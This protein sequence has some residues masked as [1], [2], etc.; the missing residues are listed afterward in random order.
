MFGV[1]TISVAGMD[2]PY[3]TPVY[4]ETQAYTIGSTVACDFLVDGRYI[5]IKVEAGTALSWRLDSFTI[6]IEPSGAWSS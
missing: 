6:D 2:D 1:L 5:A 3:E 4:T